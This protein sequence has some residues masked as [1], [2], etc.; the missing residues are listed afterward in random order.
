M[1]INTMQPVLIH[2][3]APRVSLPVQYVAPGGGIGG[4]PPMEKKDT[5]ETEVDK[6]RDK[7]KKKKQKELDKEKEKEAEDEAKS[8]AERRQRRQE[9]REE[10][11][12]E[13][14]RRARA[15]SYTNC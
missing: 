11:E 7:L 14:Q 9:Q 1:P 4:P 13:L 10:R 15:N 5:I 2:H 12:A 6:F 3:A 8:A